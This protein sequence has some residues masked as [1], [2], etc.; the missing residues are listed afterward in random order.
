MAEYKLL[1]ADMDGTLLNDESAVTERTKAALAAAVNAGVLFVAST[2]R[3]MLG[4]EDINAL[5]SEDLPFVVFNGAMALMGKS[6]RIL[7]LKPLRFEYVK[8]IYSLGVNRD[9]SVILWT[10]ERLFVSRDCEETQDYRK[11]TGA[12]MQVLEDI[13]AFEAKDVCKLLWISTPE[14]AARY[15]IEMNARF[16]GAV[17][18]HT[19]RPHFLEFVD[20]GA[21][22]ALALDAIG[23]AFGID[24]SEMIAVGD[25]YNDVSMLEYAGL[26]VA[27]QNAP[28]DI[29]K[30]CDTVTLSNNGDGVAA[31]IDKYI[32]KNIE[33]LTNAKQKI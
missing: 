1:A 12:K 5:F 27:M 19:S 17:N 24:K 16:G 31:V 9:I 30:L 33:D 29:K 26:S 13:N 18:C 11:I 23:A 22:K 32:L 4:A 3:P 21:S 20:A 2:G 10:K 8:E 14:G 28:D 7:F 15:Q 25:S 6:K